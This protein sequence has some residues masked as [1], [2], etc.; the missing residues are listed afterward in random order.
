MSNMTTCLLKLVTSNCVIVTKMISTREH[1]RVLKKKFL[2]LS[3]IFFSL[4]AVIVFVTLRHLEIGK[5]SREMVSGGWR[6]CL[7]S[8]FLTNDWY[9]MAQPR[10]NSSSSE[11]VIVNYV[12]IQPKEVIGIKPVSSILC[13]F[14]LSSCPGV[15]QWRIMTWKF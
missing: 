5:L 11:Q 1:P 10:I 12:R 8:I 13:G 9:G 15:Y 3:L 2:S 14:C 7:W 6:E 4:S